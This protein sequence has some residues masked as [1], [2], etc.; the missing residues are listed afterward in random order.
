MPW[1]ED[2]YIPSRWS[3]DELPSW[4]EIWEWWNSPDRMKPYDAATDTELNK[5]WQ[6]PQKLYIMAMMCN[7]FN[8]MLMEDSFYKSAVEELKFLA[9]VAT[10]EF[11]LGINIDGGIVPIC[12]DSG[13][14]TIYTM[15]KLMN[16]QSVL[17]RETNDVARTAIDK[18]TSDKVWMMMAYT[19]FDSKDRV[20]VM[21][22][23]AP[24]PGEMDKVIDY[25]MQPIIKYFTETKFINDAGSMEQSA[26]PE[27]KCKY[28]I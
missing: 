19:K 10:F 8:K 9:D 21:N 27:D 23:I 2:T 25:L 28:F 13:K 26:V 14:H 12:E 16:N 1:I 4:G 6:L 5:Y 15:D 22:Y 11:V 3:K 18:I 20:G 24:A 7:Q 17:F